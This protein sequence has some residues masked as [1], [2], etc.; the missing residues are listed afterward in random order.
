MKQLLAKLSTKVLLAFGA[1]LAI[2]GVTAAVQAWSPDRPTY[3]VE[4]PADHVT[5]NSI[6]NNPN[7]GD[8]RTFFD[9]KNAA[10]TNTGGFTDQVSVQD[11]QELLLRVYVHNNA[12]SS[13]NGENMNGVGVAKDAK[14]RIHVPTANA[15]A[16]RAN[17]Y[18][19]ASN[20]APLEVSD[21][22]DFNAAAPF[23]LEYVPGSAIMHTNA[24]PAGFKLSDSIVGSTGA[25]IGYTGPNGSVPGCF[26]YTGIVTIKVKVKATSFKVE[27][28]VAT[29]TSGGWV[30]NVTVK[31][32]E[33]VAYQIGFTNTGS[34]KLDNVVIRDQLPKGMSIVP[35]SSK[36]FN[37]N[38]PSGT[39]LGTD[40]VVSNGGIVI[41]NYK[42]DVNAF[43][44]FKATAPAEKDLKCGVNE[45]VNIGEARIGDKAVT[46]TAIVKV[47]KECKPEQPKPAYSCDSLTVVKTGKG[48]EI[49]ADVKYT[50]TNGAKLKQITYTFGDGK[51][52]TTD[53]TSVNYTYA[54]DGTYN[55]VAKLLIEVDGTTKTVM[56]ASCEKPVTFSTPPVVPP[57]TPENP[58]VPES[59]EE[60]PI[61][62]PA[63]VALIVAGVS[64]VSALGYRFFLGRRG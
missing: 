62:G 38:Y 39:P 48:R 19:S 25:P 22:V 55:V 33:T 6:T 56:S 12:A 11:G 15:T 63:D 21:T 13:L 9:V 34:Q 23:G 47:T 41:G 54:K 1:M 52:L 26:Q 49:K 37:S 59:P 57:E 14:V 32:G 30:E 50:A 27:K 18:V 8:E 5:F 7:Y 40:A 4:N 2:V 10:N 35:G 51:T 28:K 53:K 64:V 16:L 58:E 24:V 17:A 61:T 46:D 3:T 29:P 36:L 43:V 42:K 20:A 44:Q 60:L 45:L 31:P